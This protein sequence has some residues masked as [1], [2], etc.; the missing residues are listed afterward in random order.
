M[1]KNIIEARSLVKYFGSQAV[2]NGVHLEIPEGESFVVL[3]SKGAGKTTLLA[4]L[5]NFLAPSAGDLFIQG[6]NA[7]VLGEAVRKKLGYIMDKDLFDQQLNVEENL[8]IYARYMGLGSNEARRRITESMRFFEI[9]DYQEANVDSLNTF[10]RRC[11]RACRAILHQPKLLIVDELLSGL[12]LL[13]QNFLTDRLLDLK[14]QGLSIIFS[15]DSMMEADRLADR[16]GILSAGKLLL[17]GSPS[18]IIENEIGFEV[19]EFDCREDEV[20]YLVSKISSSYE[21]R[22]RGTKIYVYIRSGQDS[23]NV[24]DMISG[25]EMSLRRARLSDVVTKLE[26]SH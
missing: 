19:V 15:T 7:K 22:N 6:Q 14:K 17:E 26:L 9:A 12:G 11:L 20:E 21:Y 5:A 13:E 10:E 4:L 23:R 3:G 8:W 1:S 2:I 24:L 18:K 16:V 25:E